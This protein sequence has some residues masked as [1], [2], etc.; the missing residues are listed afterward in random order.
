MA[1]NKLHADFI[2]AIKGASI[3]APWN[4]L[5][6]QVKYDET[7]YAHG[8]RKNQMPPTV[9]LYGPVLSA[10]EIFL[11]A[12]GHGN[13]MMGESRQR[14]KRYLEAVLDDSTNIL[15]E[16][17][18]QSI[19][20]THVETDGTEWPLQEFKHESDQILSYIVLLCLPDVIAAD[21]ALS[22][23]L[24]D[25]LKTLEADVGNLSG[26]A[27]ADDIPDIISESAYFM[28]AI[29]AYL[30]D[31]MELRFDDVAFPRS[32]CQL[33]PGDLIRNMVISNDKLKLPVD[34]IVMS[35]AG[36]DF[37]FLKATGKKVSTIDKPVTIAE[38]RA[39]FASFSADRHWSE[40]EKMLIP[41]FPDDAPVMPETM[42]IANRIVSTRNDVNPVCNLMWRGVTSYGK[43]TGVK[44]LAAILN[45]PLLILTCHPAM[46]ISEFKSTFVPE[47]ESEGVELD[48]DGIALA[49][50]NESLMSEHL[51]CAVDHVSKMDKTEREAFLNGSAFYFNAMMDTGAACCSLCGKDLG[52]DT[53][54]VCSLYS[55]T[56][57]YFREKPLRLK[58]MQNEVEPDKQEQKSESKPG[59]K[60]IMSNYVKALVNGYMVEIQ[61]A[62]RIRDSGVL[63]GI[64]E[65]DRPGAVISL[66][67]GAMARRHKDAICVITDNVGYASCRPIDP[68]V[69]RR[70]GMIIDSYELPE[71]MLKDR[72]RRNTGCKDNSL[73]DRAYELWNKVKEFC[74]QNSI[75]EGSVSPMELERFVQAV[76]HEGIDSLEV[77]LDDCIISKSTSSID[78]QRDIRTACRTLTP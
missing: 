17:D 9:K 6:R 40:A 36:V 51:R 10:V 56:R 39:Q 12:P 25:V 28:D 14:K 64:N 41:Y 27:T 43:S 57:S 1:T 44:Q 22:G 48:M 53:E 71:K 19:S 8:F 30:Q 42:R 61:E 46:E 49:D 31:G 21:K 13:V 38:A 73:I 35:N 78:D 47:S 62:S 3:G 18:A 67:N 50:A 34:T 74:E 63:V 77:N 37:R 75:T 20:I 16:K 4:L 5:T 23:K 65:Y 45:M 54:D 29:F 72:V 66:M 58:L 32:T 26:Y 7:K 52:L 55:E 33:I 68:S 11:G 59:F 24:E 2:S 76:D 70:Q 60:H 69:L 15:M